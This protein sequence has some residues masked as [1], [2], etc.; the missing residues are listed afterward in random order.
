[1]RKDNPKIITKSGWELS[2]FEIV[3]LRLGQ[4]RDPLG[5]VDYNTSGFGISLNGL[6][7]AIR[8]QQSHEALIDFLIHHFDL[9]YNYSHY[10]AEAGHPLGNTNFHGIGI[11]VF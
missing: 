5:K 6:L 3:S 8:Y 1:M 2:F 10:D 4:Y 9:Q 11:R 7:A